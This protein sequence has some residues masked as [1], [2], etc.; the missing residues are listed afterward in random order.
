MDERLIRALGRAGVRL[1]PEDGELV[2]LARLGESAEKLV[3]VAEGGYWR[4]FRR[5]RGEAWRPG[6]RLEEERQAA[7]SVAAWG[8]AFAERAPLGKGDVLA[9]RRDLAWWLSPIATSVEGKE[10]EHG[11]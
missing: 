7:A 4:S 9:I 6:P 5:Q 10:G 1:L 11:E 3:R 2:F 8:L